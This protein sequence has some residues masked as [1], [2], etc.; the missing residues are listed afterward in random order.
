MLSGLRNEVKGYLNYLSL[1]LRLKLE[2]V[3]E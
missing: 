3:F 2:G 1:Y